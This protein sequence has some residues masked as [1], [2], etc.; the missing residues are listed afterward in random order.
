MTEFKIYIPSA[1]GYRIYRDNISREK[2]GGLIREEAFLQSF[3]DNPANTD[4]DI[5][6]HRVRHLN[7]TYSTRIS[8]DELSVIVDFIVQHDF[9]NALDSDGY[10]LVE[11]L[12][13]VHSRRV[14]TKDTIDHLSFAT[15]Y[16]HHCRPDKY[17]IYDSINVRV[18]NVFLGYEDKKRNYETYVEYYNA[19]CSFLGFDE[20]KNNDGFYVDKYIQ[21]IGGSGERNCLFEELT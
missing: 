20:L 15:K 5:V 21:I 8:A 6:Q 2:T 11:K 4:R 17:P 3:L 9:D 14:K 10:E 19:F 13:H 12:R 1:D 7:S 18:L 16:C